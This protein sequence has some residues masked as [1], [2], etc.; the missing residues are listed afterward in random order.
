[1]GTEP[2]ATTSPCGPATIVFLGPSLPVDEA[3]AALPGCYLPP[4]ACGDVLR[5]RALGARTI[6]LIDGVFEARAAVWH[7]EILL[8]LEGGIAV[9]GAGSMGALRAAELAPFGM[10]G[11]GDIFEAYR[12]GVYTDDDEVAVLH[13]DAGGGFRPLS[14][15]MV[16]IRATVA[17]A[18]AARVLTSSAGEQVI[19]CAKETFYPERSIAGAVEAARHRGV[20]GAR[21][22]RFLD[23]VTAGGYVDQKRRDALALLVTL[24]GRAWA[25]E[26]PRSPTP[27]N[28]TRFIRILHADV[29]TTPLE[30][31]DATFPLVDRVASRAGSL[32]TASD[33][34]RALAQLLHLADGLARARSISPT[35]EAIRAVHSND[36]LGL[37]CAEAPGRWAEE[38]DL[39]EAGF[40]AFVHRL[41]RIR[42]LLALEGGP[43]PDRKYLLMALRLYGGYGQFR[44][45]RPRKVGRGKRDRTRLV[46]RPEDE[47]LPLFRRVATLWG[48]VD[49]A[50]RRA[51]VE[52][53][54]SSVQRTSD[55]FRQACGLESRKSTD[56][57]LR[58][59]AL[60]RDG[61][62]ELMAT[63]ARLADVWQRPL[64]EPLG[65]E[66]GEEVS[67][68][69]DALRL[70][71]YY[72]RV[73]DGAVAVARR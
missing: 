1:M 44:R 15:P 28:R 10:I 64:M 36:G 20:D 46:D 66:A 7:K 23:F 51:G 40:E 30:H 6:A 62:G 18:V 48:L 54:A 42:T 71:G 43:A 37:G 55:E 39:D 52:A 56:A 34:L 58:A 3:R 45:S 26:A 16:N 33:L 14:E 73:K 21:L 17:A 65:V 8:A 24:S 68:F 19:A 29:M 60:T 63:Y 35:I 70:T 22:D 13:A 5:A 25:V 67:W 27:V 2:V 61:Y 49:R 41:A 57:W 50:A 72:R 53:S 4:A 9:F 47:T 38:N 11:V 32:G 12:D 59:N 31:A 69:H